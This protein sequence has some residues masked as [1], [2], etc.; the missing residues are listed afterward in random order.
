M[1]FTSLRIIMQYIYEY[2]FVILLIIIFYL[3]ANCRRHYLHIIKR[4]KRDAM[5]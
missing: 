5:K 2:L 4:W 3:F 1:S